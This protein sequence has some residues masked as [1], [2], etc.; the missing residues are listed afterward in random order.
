MSELAEQQ[1][2]IHNR[3]AQVVAVGMTILALA[4]CTRGEKHAAPEHSTIAATA[5]AHPS[6]LST[7][8]EAPAASMEN[9]YDTA[10]DFIVGFDDTNLSSPV[11]V[12]S[13]IKDPSVRNVTLRVAELKIAADAVNAGSN[14][15]IER[16]LTK[17]SL[18]QEPDVKE[19]AVKGLVKDAYADILLGFSNGADEK[20]ADDEKVMDA[21]L[22]QD[23]SD[24]PTI[25]AGLTKY[26]ALERE[27]QAELNDPNQI[28][29][30][31]TDNDAL[32]HAWSNANDDATNYWSNLDNAAA[33]AEA[34]IRDKSPK[35]EAQDKQSSADYQ[36]YLHHCDDLSTPT[37]DECAADE[38]VN[39]AQG[40][41]NS[42]FAIWQPMVKDP[43]QEARI[44]TAAADQAISDAKGDYRGLYDEWAKYVH[45]PA[46]KSRIEAAAADQAI[47]DIEGE[48][49]GL[50]DSWAAE[51]HNPTDQER[52]NQAYLKQA[53][54][55][56]AQG[57]AGLG[58]AWASKITDPALN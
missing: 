54:I 9:Q 7:H 13:A 58:D 8:S 53:K 15:S 39:D 56:Y 45:L 21:L 55:D 43:T 4:G 38:A 11:S 41:Y 20:T 5:T 2:F 48:Y 47:A 46:Q 28:D 50:A 42:L 51:V 6:T 30:W 23:P 10:Y 27:M 44:E 14:G 49:A 24:K 16:S 22:A 37:K 57:Y 36:K 31:S 35:S 33:S 25:E 52:L 17:V 32:T 40:D 26:A 29:Q 19:Q 34:T 18:I 3:L 1:G 12:P